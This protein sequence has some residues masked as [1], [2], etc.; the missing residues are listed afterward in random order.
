MNNKIKKIGSFLLILIV[1]ILVLYFALK[2]NYEEIVHQVLTVNKGYLIL[3]FLLIIT[4][5]MLKALVMK[6]TVSKFKE[7]YPFHKAL[8]L[9]VE[10]N[11]FHAI[12][13]FASGGQPYEIYSLK[14]EKLKI[15]DATNVSIQNFIV[16][17]IALVILGTIAVICNYFLH[18]F[19]SNS[20]LRYLVTIGFIC[21][22]L[23]IVILFVISF[24]KKIGKVIHVII[25]LL[26]K[27]KLVKNEEKTKAQFDKYISEFHAGAKILVQDQKNFIFMILCN[28][29][30]LLSFY[31]IP[32]ILLYSTGDFTSMNAFESIIA[33]AYIMMIGSFV[34]IPGGTGGLEY[35]FVVF[36]STF[37]KGPVLNAIMLIWRFI[38]Y[39][40]GM[41]L[42]AITLNFK[43]KRT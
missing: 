33:S 19:P 21:N 11:F 34:P 10:T 6:K 3:A 40:F 18:I 4:Y 9:V 27:I 41:I 23:V 20:F 8:R 22:F 37:I 42:G 36:Y 25:H 43:R 5:W 28:F 26:N 1:T 35:G 15:A 32:L 29:L 30:A 38:T 12:T 17:Q 7:D 16:Y 2:D 14:K 13:P 24:T 31:L 39:Y